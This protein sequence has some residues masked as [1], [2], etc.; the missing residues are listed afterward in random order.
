[1]PKSLNDTLWRTRQGSSPVEQQKDDAAPL[2]PAQTLSLEQIA[3]L[4][5]KRP[6]RIEAR[7]ARLRRPIGACVSAD[8][9]GGRG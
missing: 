1:M 4:P 5:V 8:V 6:S 9:L 2:A 3:A 7:R